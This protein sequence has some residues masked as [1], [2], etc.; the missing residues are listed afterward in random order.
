MAS[1]PAALDFH[2]ALGGPNKEARLRYLRSLWSVEA[3]EMSHI[4]V[5]GGA[6]E[7]AWTGMGAFRLA[8]KTSLDDAKALQLRL[9]EEFGIFTVVRRGLAS[10]S[11]VRITPQVFT[12]P[13]EVDMLV[14]AMRRLRA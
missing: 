10:G 9:E 11:C 5:L 8:G 2:E 4:E 6:E 12:T 13:D 14:D 1:V 7:A 3:E